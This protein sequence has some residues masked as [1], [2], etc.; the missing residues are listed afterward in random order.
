MKET[1][2]RA[3]LCNLLDCSYRN[4][5]ILAGCAYNMQDL[6]EE[7]YSMEFKKPGINSLAFAMFRLAKYD[8][9]E[10]LEEM[11][12]KEKNEEKLEVLRQLDPHK[13]IVSSHNYLD[14][15][16]YFHKNQEL[17]KNYASNLVDLFKEKTGFNLT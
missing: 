6:I 3:L 2:M 9:Q 16:V 12:E 14:T 5:E 15:R 17:Y 13:D 1:Q 8:M 4:L 10:E 11:I 7:V